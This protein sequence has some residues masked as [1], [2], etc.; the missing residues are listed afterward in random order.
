MRCQASQAR[1]VHEWGKHRKGIE[2]E[3]NGL[4]KVGMASERQGSVLKCGG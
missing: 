2:A 1:E 4:A 3:S